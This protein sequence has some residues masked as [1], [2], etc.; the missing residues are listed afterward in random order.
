M[1][2][3]TVVYSTQHRRIT[4]WENKEVIFFHNTASIVLKSFDRSIKKVNGTKVYKTVG[5]YV[6]LLLYAKKPW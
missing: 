5:L 3:F 1:T 4:H 6:D 2:Y